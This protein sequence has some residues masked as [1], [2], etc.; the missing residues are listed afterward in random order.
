[1]RPGTTQKWREPLDLQE[2]KDAPEIDEGW[3]HYLAGMDIIDA[4]MQDA[5]LANLSSSAPAAQKIKADRDVFV[6]GLEREYPA[7]GRSRE[8][9]DQGK[10]GDRVEALTAISVDPRLSQRPEIEMLGTYLEGRKV[11]AER[12]AKR[13]AVGR[14][15]TLTAQSNYDLKVQW[16]EFGNEM[17]QENL[18]FSD[19]WHRYLENDPVVG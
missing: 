9:I 13:K 17:A 6:A 10:W 11:M 12:L 15:G 18:A 4:R 16:E 3:R 19:I 7:W 5:G 1:L 14:A 2:A 8:N